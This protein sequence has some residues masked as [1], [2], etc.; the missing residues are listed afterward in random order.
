M[1]KSF[2]EKAKFAEFLEEHNYEYNEE[3]YDLIDLG[4]TYTFKGRKVSQDEYTRLMTNVFAEYEEFPF[5]PIGMTWDS[6]W[7][8]DSYSI[9]QLS[10][11]Q[12]MPFLDSFDEEDGMGDPGYYGPGDYETDYL[13]DYLFQNVDKAAEL[14]YKHGMATLVTEETVELD[15]F[16]CRIVFLGTNHP[17]HFVREIQYAISELGDIYEYDAVEDVWLL[18]YVFGAEG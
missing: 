9:T 8:G 10:E 13:T 1:D 15:G 11:N 17:T 5:R 14:V 16:V 18:M 12:I 7:H 2:T 6:G 4:S 3:T